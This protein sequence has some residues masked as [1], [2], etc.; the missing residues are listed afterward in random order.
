MGILDSILKKKKAEGAP[1]GDDPGTTADPIAAEP[2][3]VKAKTSAAEKLIKILDHLEKI[4]LVTVLVAVAAISVM[5]L[6]SAKKDSEELKFLMQDVIIVYRT[7]E[8]ALKSD[9]V[10]HAKPIIKE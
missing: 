5:R 7:L 1:E 8:N 2:A 9:F 3:P 6:L 4:I 10:E